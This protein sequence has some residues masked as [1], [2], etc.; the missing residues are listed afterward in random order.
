ML[1]LRGQNVDR[2][3]AYETDGVIMHSGNRI[4]VAEEQ[5]FNFRLAIRDTFLQDVDVSYEDEL[6][7]STAQVEDTVIR[8]A[9]WLACS[10]R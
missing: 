1:L 4:E 10:W 2:Y 6:E 8:S 3:L 9:T 7:L 5:R